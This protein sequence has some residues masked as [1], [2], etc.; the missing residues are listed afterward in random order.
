MR[1]ERQMRLKDRGISRRG[2]MTKFV[3]V[4]GPMSS[5]GNYLANVRNAILVAEQIIN[6][7]AIPFV[8]QLSALWQLVSPHS[9]Y[10]YWLPMDLAWVGKCDALYRIGGES[11][12]ADAEER[13]AEI[14]GLPIFYDIDTLSR[15]IARK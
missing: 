1:G 10:E 13:H 8:P 14:L 15:W 2:D 7:G 6:L 9:E 4:A 12:G 3:Y 5:S 11:K